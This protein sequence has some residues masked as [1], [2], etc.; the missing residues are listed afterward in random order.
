VADD[1]TLLDVRDL[2]VTVGSPSGPRPVDDVS[3]SV[4]RNQIFGIV[5]ESGSGKTMTTRAILQLLPP[6]VAVTN[7]SIRLNGTEMVNGSQRVLRP[8]RGTDIA[9]IPQHAGASLNPLVKVG[10]QVGAALRA[11][12]VDRAERRRRTLGLFE[13]LGLRDPEGV[14]KKYPHELSGGMQQRVVAAVALAARPRLLIAD[15][16]TSAL[17]PVVQL[18]FLDLLRMLQRESGMSVVLVTHDLGV[19]ARVCDE[20][21]V[22]YGGRIMEQAPVGPLFAAPQHPYTL[23]LLA[24]TPDRRRIAP[25]KPIVGQPR[26]ASV[27]GE[28]CP[29]AVRC[30]SAFDRCFSQRPPD[31]ATGDRHAVACW[32]SDPA[33]QPASTAK[34]VVDLGS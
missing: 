27:I 17:D 8:M 3:F 4:A 22:M 1:S 2:R 28:A 11:H 24:A 12:D 25:S 32:L 20:V 33:P 23:G 7:G 13:H 16:P 34:E 26:E 30:P 21:L 5:G 14:A 18:Q 15:E 10:K 19:V 9:L 6:G 29:F 31:F